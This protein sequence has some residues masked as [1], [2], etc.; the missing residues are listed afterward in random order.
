MKKS[1]MFLEAQLSVLRDELLDDMK[2]LEIIRV[3]QSEQGIAEL[4]E[5]REAERAAAEE[6]DF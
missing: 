5:R 4:C 2:K 3:L 1:Q 6:D